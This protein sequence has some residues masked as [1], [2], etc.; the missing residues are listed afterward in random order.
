M[1]NNALSDCPASVHW[2]SEKEPPFENTNPK[3]TNLLTYFNITLN[4]LFY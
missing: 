2:A 3:Y 1:L 4:G